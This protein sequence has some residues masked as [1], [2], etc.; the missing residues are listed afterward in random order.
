[1]RELLEGLCGR[2]TACNCFL[3]YLV[4]QPLFIVL[5]GRWGPHLA[6]YEVALG[7]QD[8]GR[9]T[10]GRVRFLSALYGDLS[11]LMPLLDSLPALALLD[12]LRGGWGPQMASYGDFGEVA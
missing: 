9:W 5:R 1:M 12:P 4:G 6:C 11:D 2:L 8:E 7:W 3:G 10:F